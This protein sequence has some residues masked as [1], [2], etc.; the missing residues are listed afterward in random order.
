MNMSVQIV[1]ESHSTTVDN[2]ADLASG[3]N[4]I[5]LSALGL[6]QAGELGERRRNDHI[7]AIFCSDMQRSYKSARIAFDGIEI[8]I[9][10][11]WRLREADYGDMTQQPTSIV[12][13]EKPKRI[14]TPFP[15]GESYHQ[16]TVRMRSYLADLLKF[17]DGQRVL[18][19]GHRATQYA[20]EHLI[21]GKPLEEV[22]TAPWNWQPGW[23]YELTSI[24]NKAR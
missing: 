24:Q 13:P 18:I 11:D 7:D 4:D 9:F 12:K 19:V 23:E 2:E 17:Y 1:F 21:L 20:L 5:E 16:T 10:M 6:T 3:W 8:D 15:G 14:D 22:V